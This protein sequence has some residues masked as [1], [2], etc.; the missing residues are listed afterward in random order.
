MPT[1]T[2]TAKNIHRVPSLTMKFTIA[3]GILAQVLPAI[4]EKS[5]SKLLEQ[6]VSNERDFP[7]SRA[8]M[9]ILSRGRETIAYQS[10][11][12]LDGLLKNVPFAQNMKACDP[13]SNDPDIGILSCDAGYECVSDEDSASGGR[14]TS[15]SRDL[16]EDPFFC[17]ICGDGSVMSD[18]SADIA[19]DLPGYEGLTC[20]VMAVVAYSDP[21][22]FNITLDAT[23]CSGAGMLAQQAGCCMPSYD[24]DPCSEGELLPGALYDAGGV[25]LACGFLVRYANETACELYGPDI[26]P[27]C[28]GPS[29]TTGSVV[30]T[31]APVASPSVTDTPSATDTPVAPTSNSAGRWSTRALVSMMSLTTVV[32]VGSLLLN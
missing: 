4:S 23:I 29:T 7:A 12:L 28:C 21:T 27:T 9:S 32:T 8:L 11:Q 22:I 24:C 13:S 3:A 5:P 16:Q 31:P 18:D 26:A 15:I 10:P 25:S 2:S 19:V 1:E 6:D 17:Y 14:C 20:G 30:P